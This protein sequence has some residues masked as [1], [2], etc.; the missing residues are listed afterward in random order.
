MSRVFDGGQQ[1]NIAVLF[2][3]IQHPLDSS[4]LGIA[5]QLFVITADKTVEILSRIFMIPA[6]QVCAG[7]NVFQPKRSGENLFTDAAWI[8]AVDKDGGLFRIGLIGVNALYGKHFFLSPMDSASENSD[9]LMFFSLEQFFDFG[10]DVVGT[11]KGFADQESMHAVAAHEI[12]VFFVADAAF[13][14]NG[15]AV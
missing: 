7:C 8:E 10:F 12:D 9:G 2:F 3:Q 11:H 5:L 14:D 1:Q 4:L 6:A 13:G 15:F